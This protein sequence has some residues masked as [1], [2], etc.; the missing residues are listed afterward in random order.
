MVTDY[1]DE[2][3]GGGDAKDLKLVDVLVSFNQ[4]PKSSSDRSVSGLWSAAYVQFN[5]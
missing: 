4:T 2:V 1:T 3:C 5:P